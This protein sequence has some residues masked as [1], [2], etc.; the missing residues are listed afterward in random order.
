MQ[1][2]IKK[3][4]WLEVSINDINYF[5][6][7]FLIKHFRFSC[8]DRNYKNKIFPQIYL[9]N[10]FLPRLWWSRPR[11]WSQIGSSRLW[12]NSKKLIKKFLE[13]FWDQISY[14]DTKGQNFQDGFNGEHR[15]KGRVEN[16]LK[17]WLIKFNVKIFKEC[18]I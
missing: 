10:K 13:N 15:S 6:I 1:E 12:N 8:F 18:S 14:P 16:P 9:T 17:F 5:L 7:F 11:W 3:W 2:M 4:L